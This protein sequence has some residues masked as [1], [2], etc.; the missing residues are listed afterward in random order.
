MS[1]S[2]AS[3]AREI[4]EGIKTIPRGC[5]TGC[6]SLPF[7]GLYKVRYAIALLFVAS[8]PGHEP[9]QIPSQTPLVRAS[10][11]APITSGSSN[12]S[13]PDT[14]SKTLVQLFLDPNVKEMVRSVTQHAG[15][16]NEAWR[17]KGLPTIPASLQSCVAEESDLTEEE[18][19]E[20]EMTLGDLV[21]EVKVYDVFLQSGGVKRVIVLPDGSVMLSQIAYK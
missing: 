14:N 12:S 9:S 13:S 17:E 3:R 21:D 20:L 15:D 7:R 19:R 4:P 16:F 2:S 1:E 5:V 10:A 18:E 11:T 8:F 6:L